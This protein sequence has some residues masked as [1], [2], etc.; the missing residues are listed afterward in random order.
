MAQKIEKLY[1]SASNQRQLKSIGVFS[2]KKCQQSNGK[3]ASEPANI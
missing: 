1:R 2:E 3:F